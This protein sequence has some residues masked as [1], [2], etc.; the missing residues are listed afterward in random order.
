M[1]S[2]DAPGNEWALDVSFQ[3][4]A[5][6][7]VAERFNISLVAAQ[8]DRARSVL[9]AAV[10]KGLTELPSGVIPFPGIT[11]VTRRAYAW[12]NEVRLVY[13]SFLQGT[14]NSEILAALPDGTD[15][16]QIP[17]P[18][19]GGRMYPSVSPSGEKITFVGQERTKTDE[20][21]Y[22]LWLMDSNG[23]NREVIVRQTGAIE[24]PVWSPDGRFIAYSAVVPS[25]TQSANQ[26]ASFVLFV[27]DVEN[28]LQY[29]ITKG[30]PPDRFPAWMPDSKSLI[31]SARTKATSTNGIIK[32]DIDS[33]ELTLLV[34]MDR[35]EETQPSVSPDG[36]WIA[37]SASP[38]PEQNSDI[39]VF[40]LETAEIRQLTGVNFDDGH[41]NFPAWHPDTKTIYFKSFRTG[42]AS[43]TIWAVGIQGNNLRQVTFG[44]AD[45]APFL[46]LVTAFWPIE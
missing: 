15:I 25:L 24:R 9:G 30:E 12:I 16:H 19:K 44:G 4:G 13:A 34:D 10:G 39:Y 26:A 1:V 18:D 32:I 35:L 41:D 36:K 7:S 23:D 38:S 28:K 37:Y 3:I 22:L 2:D 5:D 8:D 27:Y 14:S 42:S 17:N 6:L 11:T 20:I 45:S 40:N 33:G 21:L 29:Q 31:F 46:G 43:P